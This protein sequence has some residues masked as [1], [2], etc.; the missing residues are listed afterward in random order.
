MPNSTN[1][2]NRSIGHLPEKPM[3]GNMTFESEAVGQ[4]GSTTANLYNAFGHGNRMVE[5]PQKSQL[6][7]TLNQRTDVTFTS[8]QSMLHRSSVVL[9]MRRVHNNQA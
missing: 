8:L 9:Q 2:D 7:H 1:D 6:E 5:S 4:M 3:C